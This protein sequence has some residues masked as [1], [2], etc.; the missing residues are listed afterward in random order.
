MPS[1]KLQ[2]L[3]DN[4]VAYMVDHCMDGRLNRFTIADALECS[5]RQLSRAFED[6]TYT[7]SAAL[8]LI[9][10][11]KAQ[12]LLVT[13]KKWPIKKIATTLHFRNAKHFATCYKKQFGKTPS[14]ERENV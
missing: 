1:E 3:Y 2:T 13:K 7:L 12:E 11:L 10:L 8:R 5:P 6:R 14:D 4:A 9:R